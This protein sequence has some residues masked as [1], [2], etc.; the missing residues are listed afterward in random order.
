MTLGI[1]GAGP[2]GQA[3]YRVLSQKGI[4]V[5]FFI[6][7]YK[8]QKELFGIPIYRL[9][10]APREAEIFVSIPSLPSFPD[11]IKPFLEKIFPP[12]KEQ[13]KRL[14][15]KEVY[16]FKETVKLH[17]RLIDEL[18]PFYSFRLRPIPKGIF[19]NLKTLFK[20][21]ESLKTLE[22]IKKFRENPTAEN[23]PFP[24]QEVQYFPSFVREYFNDKK[25]RFV[26]MGAFKGDTLAWL[27][28]LFK[29]KVEEIFALEP[30]RE[31]IEDIH[32]VL[33]F[34]EKK[35]PFRA[36]VIP[37]GVREE[38]SVLKFQEMGS[39]SAI[40]QE[41]REVPVF[42]PDEVLLFAKPNFIKMDIEVAELPALKGAEKPIRKYRPLL[43]ISVYHKAEDLW[44]IPFWIKENFPFYGFKLRWHGHMLNEII[45]YC[46]PQN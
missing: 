44:K 23:Y 15:F 38:T 33:G 39:S 40:S 29:E 1:Y 30:I 16:S 27:L 18:L 37:A 14:G 42:K 8:P 35:S 20:D 41:G 43:A 31:F 7:Q 21:E 45:L 12:T 36:T 32:Q 5:D 17:P 28:Y 10:N 6:D 25:V 24:S 34:F 46:I 22:R 26:D 2:W 3:L 19:E 9:Q 11:E 13:L 4:K